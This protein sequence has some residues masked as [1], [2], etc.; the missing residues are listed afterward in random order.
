MAEEYKTKTAPRAKSKG[1]Y[2]G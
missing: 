2:S 1:D